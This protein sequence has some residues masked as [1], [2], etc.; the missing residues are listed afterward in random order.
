MNAV[1]R[2]STCPICEQAMPHANAV[3]SVYP[4]PQWRLFKCKQCA[5]IETRHETSAPRSGQ[6]VSLPLL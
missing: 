2:I 4:S 6:K 3:K 5:V 1:S